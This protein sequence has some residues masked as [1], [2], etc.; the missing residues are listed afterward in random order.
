MLQ[1]VS[2]RSLT[3]WQIA[4]ILCGYGLL[5]AALVRR[6]ILPGAKE[7]PRPLE[8]TVRAAGLLTA[9]IPLLVAGILPALLSEGVSA[10][11][12]SLVAR[13]GVLGWA[14]WISA[15]AS[16]VLIVWAESHFRRAIEPFL[17]LLH[18]FI[19]LDWAWRLFLGGLGN[20]VQLS[21]N[22]A[23]LLEGAG[24]VLWSLAIFVL[25]LLILMGNT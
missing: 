20:V 7:D 18:D 12:V 14:L 15:L 4:A 17:G 5:T 23:E 21:Q 13:A 2:L 8:I 9:S 22:V 19:S 16:G 10:S 11:F 3:G 25:L 24:A 1:K 6:L